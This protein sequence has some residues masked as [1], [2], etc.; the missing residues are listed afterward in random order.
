MPQAIT[1]SARRQWRTALLLTLLIFATYMFLGSRTALWDRDEGWYARAVA[2]MNRDANWLYPTY[3][4][5]PFL[6]KP[7]LA[8]WLW[9]GLMRVLGPSE[10]V[11]RLV[12]AM[13]AALACL[14]TWYIGRRIWDVR[15]GL[16]AMAVLAS[17]LIVQVMAQLMTMDAIL[18]PMLL[19]AVACFVAS[20]RGDA[21][22]V[23]LAGMALALSLAAL[24]KFPMNLVPLLM[25]ATALW[26]G[27]ASMRLRL[28]YLLMCT[29]VTALSVGVYLLWAIPANAASGGAIL[30]VGLSE[31]V[32]MRMVTPLAQHG[33][34][35]LLTYLLY[36]PYYLPVLL[37]GIFPWV[38]HLPGALSAVLR[39]R[40]IS[41]TGRAVILGLILPLLLAMTL[42]VTKLPH[43]ILPI[44]PGLALAV[45]ATLTA[46]NRAEVPKADQT[47]MRR[48]VWLLGPIGVVSGLTLLIGPWFFSWP[49]LRLGGAVVGTMTLAMTVL[50]IRAHLTRGPLASAKWV[51]AG[52]TAIVLAWAVLLTP[53]IEQVKALPAIAREIN[54]QQPLGEVAC[55]KFDE[56]SL[57]FY[58]GRHIEPL[59]AT[60]QQVL[61]W[62]NQPA[63]GVLI[64]PAEQLKNLEQAGGPAFAPDV[65][66]RKRLLNMGRFRWVLLVALRRPSQQTSTPPASQ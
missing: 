61:D 32:L 28:R 43:Y 57:H 10:V 49:D 11:L 13:G 4:D 19:G 35:S 31:H 64:L 5:Q 60:P 58:L 36:L 24:T 6:E 39:G 26:F 8:F 18:L 37:V 20:A 22:I 47:W 63:P 9:A 52:Q 41:R 3:N 34:S 33:S 42:V 15:T 17:S 66:I 14:L 27:R 51:L 16:W 48:G 46:W 62:L 56:P 54:K 29:A 2:E 23:H 40:L 55:F 1:L 65:I 45:A 59:Y 12:S 50:S 30:Q 38:L 44:W 7:I 53:A 25:I 21:K